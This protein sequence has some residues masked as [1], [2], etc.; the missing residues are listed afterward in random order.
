MGLDPLMVLASALV[1]LLVG[2]TGMGGGALMTPM[3]VLVFGVAPSAAITS[4]L[5][6]ALLMRPAGLLV[7]WRRGTIHAPLA[8][9]LSYGSVPAALAGTATLALLGHSPAAEHR[10]ELALGAALVVGGLAMVV[11]ARR[12]PGANEARPVVRPG[13]TVAVGVLGGFMVGLTS[14]GAGSL[15]LVLLVAL[16][17]GLRNDQLVGTDLAQSIPLT[18]AAT[19]GTLLFNHVGLALTASIVVGSVPAVVVGSLFSSRAHGPGL[20]RVIAAVVV[21]SGLKYLGLPA[22]ALGA[23][24]AAEVVALVVVGV[25]A[26]RSVAEPVQDLGATLPAR[27]D[28]HP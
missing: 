23:V 7:H 28:A 27:L 1:G 13:L 14:V 26:R 2:L 4:D 22:G 20:R 24:V 15:I 18:F 16:Y 11:R 17:P 3:L 6:A 10:L 25:V 21:A 8:R 19:L 9:Y 5:V 12:R